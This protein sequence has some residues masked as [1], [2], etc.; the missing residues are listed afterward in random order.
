MNGESSLNP[1]PPKSTISKSKSKSAVQ[2]ISSP[3]TSVNDTWIAMAIQQSTTTNSAQK[4][5]KSNGWNC[6]QCTLWNVSSKQ[7][8]T[9]CGHPRHGK[10]PKKKKK[11]KKNSNPEP[12][13][14]ADQWQCVCSTL[15]EGPALICKICLQP[16]YQNSDDGDSF[17]A[18]PQYID[19]E[20][21][22]AELDTYDYSSLHSKKGYADKVRSNLNPKNVDSKEHDDDANNAWSA[23][24]GR[25]CPCGS[26]KK[27]KKCCKKLGK[28]QKIIVVD[29]RNGR[30]GSHGTR[31]GNYHNNQRNGDA[32]GL[33]AIEDQVELLEREVAQYQGPKHMRNK[34]FHELQKLKGSRDK[35]RRKMEQDKRNAQS[36]GKNK[37]NNGQNGNANVNNAANQVIA[38]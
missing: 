14:S 16:R 28:H 24:G 27:Y 3:K 37:S 36:N 20:D 34:I 25:K 5:N 29:N 1:N 10:S 38:I 6:S 12:T 2:Q 26:G 22:K 4:V 15:N 32:N 19:D 31:N 21:L 30:N 33:R 23:A 13:P 9:A 11:K 35:L 7:K 17:Y 18:D 8:C